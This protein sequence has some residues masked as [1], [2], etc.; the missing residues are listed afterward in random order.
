MSEIEAVLDGIV[1][2]SMTLNP[3]WAVPVGI[4]QVLPAGSGPLASKSGLIWVGL[5]EPVESNT[6]NVV[7]FNTCEPRATPDAAYVYA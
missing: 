4:A 7:T 6:L 3:E 5:A 1:D 2:R